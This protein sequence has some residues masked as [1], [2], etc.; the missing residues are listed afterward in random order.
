MTLLF[1]ITTRDEWER[2]RATG[3]YT[4]PSLAADGFIHLSYARQWLGAANRFY[5]GRRG[6]VLLS[7]DPA[8][9]RGEV[10]DEAADGDVFPH[11]YGALDAGAV[12]DVRELAVAAD[13]SFAAL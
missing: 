7:I 5:R 3:T 9:L 11:L 4:P 2:A 8:R 10:R 6:L 12:V 13:G 1:H